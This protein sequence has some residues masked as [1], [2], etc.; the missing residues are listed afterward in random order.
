M[1]PVEQL[2]WLPPEELTEPEQA[3][4]KRATKKRKLFVFLREQRQ[5]IF[6]EPLQRELIEMYRQTGAGKVPL[7]PARLALLTLLQC[8]AGVAD[9][10]AVELT[11]DSKRWQM[12]LDCLGEDT[13][14]CSQKTLFDFRMRLQH[15][16]LDQRL[17]E[18]TVAVARERGGFDAKALR[19]ALDSSPLWG[20]GRVEDTINLIG[21]AGR[22]VIDCLAALT[23]QTVAEVIAAIGLNLFE[24]ASLK[25]GAGCRLERCRAETA[26]AAAAV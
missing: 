15:T 9:H 24:S 26:S 17:L 8:Y 4:A 10:E 7:A 5:V 18:R 14:L 6:D 16:G 23:E 22:Q 12:V 1:R 25:G 13:P 2:L 3:I 21:H 11:A 19:A 20:H